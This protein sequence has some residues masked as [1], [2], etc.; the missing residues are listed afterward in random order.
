MR[1]P[2]P[3]EP[4]RIG[5]AYRYRQDSDGTVYERRGPRGFR[6]TKLSCGDVRVVGIMPHHVFVPVHGGYY[7]LVHACVVCV[8]CPFCG[9]EAGQLC[10]HNGTEVTHTHYRRREVYRVWRR[11][12]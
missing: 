12:R 6:R 5:T 10:R 4:E 2:P 3:Q 1:P 8:A 9:A 11:T 7:L